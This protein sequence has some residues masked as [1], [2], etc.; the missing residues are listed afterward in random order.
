MDLELEQY[1]K[2][3][4]ALDLMISELRLKIDGMQREIDSL[5]SVAAES[6][7]IVS[8]FRRDLDGCVVD[9]NKK[10]KICMRALFSKYVQDD[11]SARVDPV[12]NLDP[13]MEFNRDREHMER[14]LDALKSRMVK[15][16]QVLHSDHSKLVREGVNLTEEMNLLRREAKLLRRQHRSLDMETDSLIEGGGNSHTA[17]QI[18]VSVEVQRELEIQEGQVVSLFSFLII[19]A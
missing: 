6:Q 13:Q 14:N 19:V 1:H 2:S 18:D 7:G 10:L 9:D 15:D 5:H 17:S 3:N 11:I 4:S 12:G 16:M 8:R